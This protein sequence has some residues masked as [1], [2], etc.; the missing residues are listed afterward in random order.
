MNLNDRTLETLLIIKDR[1]LNL[2]TLGLYGWY[3]GRKLVRPYRK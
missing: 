1:I 3:Q 2:L